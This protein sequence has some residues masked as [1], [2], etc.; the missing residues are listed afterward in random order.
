MSRG[1]KPGP[2]PPIPPGIGAIADVSGLWFINNSS[3][4]SNFTQNNITASDDL[5]G[6]A[7]NFTTPALVPSNGTA[8]ITVQLY[9]PV[10]G[11]NASLFCTLGGALFLGSRKRRGNLSQI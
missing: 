6:N 8:M 9:G 5:N 1:K 3:S 11:P 2:I 4:G 10:P 7:N